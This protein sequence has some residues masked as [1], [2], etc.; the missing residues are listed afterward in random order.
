MILAIKILDIWKFIKQNILWFAIPI[1]IIIITL[2]VI[3]I[4]KHCKKKGGK[5]KNERKR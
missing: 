1:D 4:V 5:K 3:V 2:L